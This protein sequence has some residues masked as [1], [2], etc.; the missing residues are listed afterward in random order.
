MLYHSTN[1]HGGDI[2]G[3]KIVCDFSANT[4]PYGTP[5][6]VLK[7]AVESLANLRYYPDPYCRELVQAISDFEGVPA[8]YI[9][10]GNG[11]AELIYA[12]CEALRPQRAVE[13]APTFSE[14]SLALERVGCTVDR[15]PLR[16]A[17][18]FTLDEWFPDYIQRTRPEAVFLC[19]PNNPTGRII[20][21]ELLEKILACCA[22]NEIRLFVDECFL[23]LSDGGSSLKEFLSAYPCLFILKAFTKSY[24]M[25]GLRLGYC[26]SGDPALLGKMAEAVQPWNVSVPAQAAGVAALQEQPFVQRARQTIVKEKVWLKKELET[27]GFWVCPS[28]ANF[29][30]FQGPKNLRDA[31]L[32]RGISIRS[33][34]NYHGLS[35]GWFRIAVKLPEENAVLISAIRQI[36]GKE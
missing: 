6:G 3:E 2:Y 5:S 24:G 16:K 28:Q 20:Q 31:L 22:Q 19:N 14:Y 25:A 15:Y 27:L 7:A 32:E 13:L 8:D 23:D 26:L 35:Q 11:A 33:C 30:L 34:G 21:R 12:Y 9:L 36:L 10:C 1:P 17:D 18:W 4:N 29:L